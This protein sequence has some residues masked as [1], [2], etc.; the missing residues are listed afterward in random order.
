VSIEHLAAACCQAGWGGQQTATR[1]G[2]ASSDFEMIGCCL[3]LYAWV[4][5][6]L[7]DFR[8]A[9]AKEAPRWGLL[10]RKMKEGSSRW[11][12]DISHLMAE[13][14]FVDFEA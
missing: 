9:K 3:P 11:G 2:A 8:L 1:V 14:C 6:S 10:D 4:S 12:D 13:E 7:A 5:S